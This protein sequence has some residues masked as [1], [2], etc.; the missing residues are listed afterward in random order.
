[1]KKL[2]EKDRKIGQE[3]VNERN[4]VRQQFHTQS[5]SFFNIFQ[6]S[7]ELHGKYIKANNRVNEYL[8]KMLNKY[9][10]R[11]KANELDVA[12]NFDTG[13]IKIDSAEAKTI[14]K[15]KEN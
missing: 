11:E 3:L 14:D 13:E 8:Q 12:F 5:E 9:D 4:R 7:A 15:S 10:L 6:R 2:D 1:M